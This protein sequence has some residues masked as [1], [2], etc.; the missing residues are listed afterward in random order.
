M[1]KLLVLTSILALTG[2][3]LG[4]GTV[5]FINFSV[6]PAIDGRVTTAAG[7]L[8]GASYWGQ[9][10]AGAT[11]DSLSAV[12]AP[13][14]FRNNAAGAATGVV[15]GGAVTIAGIPAGGAAFVQLRAW[16][17][18]SGSSWDEASGNPVGEFGSSGI[19]NLASTGDPTASPPGLPAAL[20]GLQPFTLEVVPE[21]STWALLALGLGALAL[22]R[23]K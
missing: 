3:V 23:R 6:N 12:G 4:Q 8:A 16:A 19:I 22:R 18:A 17:A 10:F 1:K 20:V 5:N 7:T 13:V 9:L 21:P 15:S 2:G 11:A 14:A